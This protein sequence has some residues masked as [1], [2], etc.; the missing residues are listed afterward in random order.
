T[1]T[2]HHTLTH[3]ESEPRTDTIVTTSPSDDTT[4]APATGAQGNL[5]N[6]ARQLPIW[7]RPSLLAIST[8]HE[9]DRKSEKFKDVHRAFAL[10]ITH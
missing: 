6:L 4:R 10:L 8:A 2:F 3:M 1:N 9:M 7:R 5:D